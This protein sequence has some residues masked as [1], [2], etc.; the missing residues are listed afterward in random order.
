MNHAAAEKGPNVNSMDLSTYS[1]GTG[2]AVFRRPGIFS[3]SNKL[4][5]G[6]VSVLVL[7]LLIMAGSLIYLS[8]QTHQRQLRTIQEERAKDAAAQIN[9]YMDDLQRKLGF[10]ARVRGLTE[11]SLG[12]QANLLEG[13]ARHNTAYE[14]LTILDSTGQ[15]VQLGA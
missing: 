5:F 10:L 11:M 13:L 4:R 8:F 3:I 1:T 6:V 12:V 9:A 2:T 7:A 14:T 15:T